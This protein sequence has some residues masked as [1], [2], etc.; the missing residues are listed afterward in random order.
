MLED[1]NSLDGA[2]L[3]CKCSIKTVN[4][5]TLELIAINEPRC[6]K[7]CFHEGHPI[8]NANSSAI[9]SLFDIS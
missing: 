6:K 3:E 1:T 4:I 7:T 8:S 9:S 2:Q 5:G